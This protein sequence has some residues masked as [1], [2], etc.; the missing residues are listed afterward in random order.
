MSQVA[1]LVLALLFCW[2][3]AVRSYRD[4]S[5]FGE[6]MDDVA[7]E[8]FMR[9]VALLRGTIEGEDDALGQR[10]NNRLDNKADNAMKTF[11]EMLVAEK[12][13]FDELNQQEQE[14]I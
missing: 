5:L 14:K 4:Q 2:A 12:M 13:Y 8:R 1:L 3:I 9:K 11:E 10:F 7:M 6:E